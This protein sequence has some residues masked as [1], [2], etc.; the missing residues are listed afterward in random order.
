MEVVLLAILDETLDAFTDEPIVTPFPGVLA[1]G[2]GA[3]CAHVR[4]RI[5]LG[6][7]RRDDGV[8]VVHEL[9]EDED[10]CER[11]FGS[12]VSV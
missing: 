7:R 11:F 9:G 12:G 6:T 5:G 3:T 1:A 10:E 4:V 8:A 2:S